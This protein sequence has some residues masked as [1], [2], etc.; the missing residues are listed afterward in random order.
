MT[1]KKKQRPEWVPPEG[2]DEYTTNVMKGVKGG[3]DGMPDAPAG[4]RTPYQGPRRRQLTIDDYVKG[5]LDHD[6]TILA[7]TI[8]LIESNAARHMET[9]QEV[10]RQILPHTVPSI[11]IGIT[12]V[13]GVGKSTFIEAFGRYLCQQGHRVAVLAVDPSSSISGGS[14]LGDKTRMEKL[15][16]E[17]NA[18]IRPSPSSGTLGGVTRKSRETIIVCEAGGFDVILVETVGVGQSEVTVRSMVDF[19]LLLML[20]GA[21]DE[22]QGIKKGVTELADAIVVNKADGANKSAAMAARAEYSRA[23]RY[24]PAVTEGWK[25]RAYTCSAMTG[26]GI[27]QIWSLVQEFRQQ[28]IASSVFQ[29]RRREQAR[30]WMHAM[31]EEHLR[32][33]FLHHPDVQ[34]L[35]PQIEQAV[36]DG[37]LPATTAAK[38]LLSAYD[39]SDPLDE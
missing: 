6:R 27:D 10:L 2:G 16:A 36:I 12:G 22:L 34:E 14:I 23:L 35:R 19:F 1:M 4:E 5:V 3:H 25:S 8:T 28:T 15:A 32:Y 39:Q 13:P 38:K 18:F 29:T 26:D 37:S 9:A 20:P 17:P 30:D 21:G 33:R 11:R 7:R 24:I 31:I